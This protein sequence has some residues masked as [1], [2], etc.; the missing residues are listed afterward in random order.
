VDVEGVRG[1][2]EEALALEPSE[3]E[4]M[5]SL[6]RTLVRDRYTW[7]AVADRS[8]ELYRWLLGRGEQPHFV[9][10]D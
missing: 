7:E 2:M 1:A 9:R 3:L 4:R 5:G 6:G 10:T 8:V